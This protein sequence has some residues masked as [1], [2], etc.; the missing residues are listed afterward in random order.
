[1]L[2]NG[3][4]DGFIVSVSEGS[5]IKITIFS[6]LMMGPMVMFDELRRVDCDKVIVDD[7][8]TLHVMQHS[9][10]LIWGAYY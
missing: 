8:L 6:Q 7:F 2:S 10:L 3:T 1:M 4:I 9:T 5:K